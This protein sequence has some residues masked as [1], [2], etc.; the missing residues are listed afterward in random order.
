MHTAAYI[1]YNVDDTYVMFDG[2][3]NAQLEVEELEEEGGAREDDLADVALTT[4]SSVI[5]ERV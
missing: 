3:I 1:R 4:L 2:I 5:S